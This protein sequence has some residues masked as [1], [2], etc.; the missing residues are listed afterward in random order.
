ML[1]KER[2]REKLPFEFNLYYLHA[3]FYPV[4][5]AELNIV[6]FLAVIFKEMNQLSTIGRVYVLK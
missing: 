3:F 6:Y 2:D 1:R 5:I 4:K